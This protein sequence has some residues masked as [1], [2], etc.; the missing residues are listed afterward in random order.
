VY[1][2]YLEVGI[3]YLLDVSCTI[4]IL[5]DCQLVFKIVVSPEDESSSLSK[6]YVVSSILSDAG[7]CCNTY[8]W[9]FAWWPLSKCHMVPNS[10]VWSEVF[11]WLFL[12]ANHNLCNFCRMS[13]WTIT[14]EG[15]SEL[16]FVERCH[17][18]RLHYRFLLTTPFRYAFR[19]GIPNCCRHSSWTTWPFE[20]R[21][22]RRRGNSVRDW[23]SALRDIPEE[24]WCWK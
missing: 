17:N 1:Y 24:W 23:P 10:L 18:S 19:Y 9:C 5:L 11:W 7:K 16:Q 15:V 6:C 22:I 12:F 14:L 21:A 4:L 3:I 20:L 8:H 13:F 2:L